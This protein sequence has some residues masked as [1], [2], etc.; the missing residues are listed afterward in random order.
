ME[1]NQIPAVDLIMEE[2]ERL[3]A[4]DSNQLSHIHIPVSTQ[5]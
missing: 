1:A 2:T 5:V 4:L 3:E